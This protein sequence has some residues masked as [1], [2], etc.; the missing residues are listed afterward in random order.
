MKSDLLTETEINLGSNTFSE[1]GFYKLKT[2]IK[3]YMFY[4]DHSIMEWYI[5]ECF[6]KEFTEIWP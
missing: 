6:L 2:W 3:S 5:H 4:N 1:T